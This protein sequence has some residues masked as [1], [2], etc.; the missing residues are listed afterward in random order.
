MTWLS[1]GFL[2]WATAYALN[3]RLSR[4]PRT[5]IAGF[6]VPL[7]FGLTIVVVW[8]CVVRGLEIPVVLL[9]APSVIATTFVKSLG[10]LWVY[11][12]LATYLPGVVIK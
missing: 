1:A 6:A 3:V 4:L 7:I 9:P 11:P 8:E 10:I 2:I 12:P 5:S